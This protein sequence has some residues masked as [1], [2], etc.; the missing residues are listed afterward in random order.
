MVVI[1]AMTAAYRGDSYSAIVRGTE[2]VGSGA[3]D[4]NV[5]DL[6]L[7]ALKAADLGA[8]VVHQHNLSTLCAN[9]LVVVLM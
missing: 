2:Q 4:L 1:Q 7:V 8:I 3:V 9:S 5:V 6:G